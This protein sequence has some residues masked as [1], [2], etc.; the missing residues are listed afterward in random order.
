MQTQNILASKFYQVTV[1]LLMTQAQKV[2]LL[3]KLQVFRRMTT[4]DEQI[5]ELARSMHTHLVGRYQKVSMRTH[6]VARIEK[7]P[8][9]MALLLLPPQ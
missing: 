7:Q 5:E 4:T 6:P 1:R 3:R 8:F 9:P 2:K